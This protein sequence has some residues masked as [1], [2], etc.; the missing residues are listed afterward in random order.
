VP[1][2]PVMPVAEPV[3]PSPASRSR[4]GLE[5]AI[6]WQ[7]VLDAGAD[8]GAHAIAQRTSLTRGAWAVGIALA[9]GPSLRDAPAPEVAVELSRSQ[10]ALGVARRFGGL[11]LGASAGA[12]FYRRT[13]LATPSGLAPTPAS[14]TTAFVAGPELRWRWRPG[15]GYVGIE[16]AAG[17]DIVV[18]APE[19]AIVR[20]TTVDSLDQIRTLQPRFGLNIIAGLQ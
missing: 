10:A 15:G 3:T 17:L 18:G 1:M 14:T 11:A 8:A 13:T 2:A 20:G 7:L 16:A 9:L 6:G 12:V 19:L 4:L 5:L